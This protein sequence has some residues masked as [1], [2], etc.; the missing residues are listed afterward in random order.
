M[1]H[2]ATMNVMTMDDKLSLQRFWLRALLLGGMLWGAIPLINLPFIT[3]GSQDSTFLISAVILNGLTITPASA[4]AFW[5]RRIACIW[6]TINGVLVMIAMSSY[7]LRTQEYRVGAMV[8][9]G[10]SA[11]YA[12][13]LDMIEIRHWATARESLSE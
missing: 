10:V 9:A 3:R 6:L 8:G 5:H 4:L 13:T 12:L 11:L 1:G 7:V 2:P